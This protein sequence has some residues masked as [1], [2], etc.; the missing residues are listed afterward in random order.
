MAVYKMTP[1]K[2]NLIGAKN[3][4]EFSKK[5]FEL[6]DRKRTVLIKEMM[7]LID[8]AEKIQEE[9]AGSFE[10][11]Y[12][13]LQLANMTMGVNFVEE[14]AMSLEK[15]E[16]FEILLKSVMGTEIPYIKYEKRP[17]F[18]EY[19]FFRTNPAF[20][21]AVLSFIN[22]RYLI[23]NLAQIE[24]SVFKLAV[25]IMKTQKRANALEKI[26]IPRY[27]QNIKFIQEVLEEKER[28]DFFRLKKV[29]AKKK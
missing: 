19:G 29:K 28:E 3:S 4:L 8:E 21:K 9:I 14:I 6:L 12:K 25:E 11:A 20:D 13:A 7:S 27:T 1:T 22:I 5:G 24:N 15:E 23:Y 16:G 17:F 2:A 18:A 10:E 26:Q